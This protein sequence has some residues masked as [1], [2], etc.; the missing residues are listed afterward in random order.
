MIYSSVLVDINVYPSGTV[1][2]NSLSFIILYYWYLMIANLLSS[3]RNLANISTSGS[4]TTGA[5]I[6]SI[7]L[8]LFAFIFVYSL[9]MSS[10][11]FNDF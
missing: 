10:I 1:K 8:T 3:P 5:L 9:M 4:T 11:L 7:Y 2:C 6:S